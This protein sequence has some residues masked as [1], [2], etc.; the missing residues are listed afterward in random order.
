[1]LFSFGFILSQ[2]SFAAPAFDANTI[3]CEGVI[4][5]VSFMGNIDTSSLKEA[6]ENFQ[7]GMLTNEDFEKIYN[8]HVADAQNQ[9]APQPEP[10]AP[11]ES[12][13]VAKEEPVQ[14]PE[15]KVEEVVQVKK[16][17]KPNLN[18]KLN[19]PAIVSFAIAGGGFG[20]SFVTYNS[21]KETQTTTEQNLM[22]NH[23]CTIVS[24]VAAITGGVLMFTAK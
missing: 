1:M 2:T 23:A 5:D 24:G 16:K 10:P 8:Q 6:C 21:Y 9:A 7:F 18:V 13:D 22:I 15:E 4:S 19:T 20:C 11:Q 12:V 17:K 14:A 3:D